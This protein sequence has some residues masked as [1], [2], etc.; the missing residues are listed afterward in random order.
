[1]V[2][3]R[4]SRKGVKKRP[5]FSIIVADSKSPRNGKFLEKIGFYNPCILY[6]KKK[7]FYIFKKR[8]IFWKNLGAQLSNTVNRLIKHFNIL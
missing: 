2:I 5:F 7:K 4:L 8:L 3:I 6:N 1:M